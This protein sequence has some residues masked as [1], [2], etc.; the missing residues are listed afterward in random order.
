LPATFDILNSHAFNSIKFCIRLGQSLD[1][2]LCALLA[3]YTYGIGNIKNFQ[4]IA[5]KVDV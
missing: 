2:K 1:I 5:Y 4:V 3:M